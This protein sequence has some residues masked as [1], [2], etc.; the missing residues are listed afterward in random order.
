MKTLYELLGVSPDASDEA[1][2]KAYRKLAKMHH[3][4]LNPNDPDAA[5]RFREVT[6][7]IA[8]LCDAKRRSAYNQRLVRERRMQRA[9]IVATSAFAAILIG[10][11]VTNGSAWVGPAS[12]TSV[13]DSGTTYDVVQQPFRVSTARAITNIRKWMRRCAGVLSPVA[14][15]PFMSLALGAAARSEQATTAINVER[16]R[17]R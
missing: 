7:S 16:G 1:L 2:K 5:R 11:V 9:C 12:S 15:E 14:I 4:D 8:I 10:I 17:S 13:V 3:P 6:V